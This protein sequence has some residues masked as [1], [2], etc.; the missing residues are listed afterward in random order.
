MPGSGWTFP[1]ITWT[2]LLILSFP[3][4]PL[5]YV[6]PDAH[7]PTLTTRLHSSIVR[8][9][10]RPNFRKANF[11]GMNSALQTF[12]WAHL[13]SLLTLD[14]ALN[15][16][17]NILWDHLS[18]YVP[19]SLQFLHSYP[20]WF[21]TAVHKNL[22]LGIVSI[23]WKPCW[24]LFSPKILRPSFVKYLIVKSRKNSLTSIETILVLHS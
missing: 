3:S 10:A 24:F 6:T 1:E 20:V 23:F 4:F 11:E 13:L 22:P 19:S 17:Y 8:K 16:F 5:Y 2:A 15:T 7:H 12:S 21:I 18:C 14:K 9:P